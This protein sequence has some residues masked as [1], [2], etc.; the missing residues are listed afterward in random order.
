MSARHCWAWAPNHD[1][2]RCPSP[3]IVSCTAAAKARKHNASVLAL[4][5][6]DAPLGYLPFL[7][8][9]LD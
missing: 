6:I 1:A 4:R 2:R 3:K 5:S 8:E 7:L 9:C